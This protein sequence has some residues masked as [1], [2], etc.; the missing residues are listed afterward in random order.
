MRYKIGV[1]IR[2]SKS[3]RERV[4]LVMSSS[5]KTKFHLIGPYI[6]RMS[7][8]SFSKHRNNNVRADVF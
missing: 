7:I 5:A 1:I 8:T 3:R 2:Q 6:I 4:A